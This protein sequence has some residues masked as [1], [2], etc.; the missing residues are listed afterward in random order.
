MPIDPQQTVYYRK[1]RFSTRLPESYLYAPS[2]Y[3]LRESA[4]GEFQ[5]GLT[6]FATRMLGDFVEMEISVQPGHNLTQGQTIG[7]IEGFKALSD[8]YCVAEGT[9]IRRNEALD[10]NPDLLDKDPY[11][12]GWLFSYNGTTP[13]GA[14][15]VGGYVALLD[16]AIDKMLE[17]EKTDEKPQC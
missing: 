1:G 11:D 14:V 12:T 8:I 10:S 4:P 16:A 2:H 5:V 6:K 17:A 7:W 15:D 9:F 3:W 13:R